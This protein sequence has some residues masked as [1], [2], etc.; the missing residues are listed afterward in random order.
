MH[1]L[2]QLVW[3]LWGLPLLGAAATFAAVPPVSAQVVVDGSITMSQEIVP[4]PDSNVILIPEE[5]GARR[6]DNLIH[7]FEQFN[8]HAGEIADFTGAQV[9]QSVIARVT[10]YARS[11]LAGTIRLTGSLASSDLFLLNPSGFLL[12][13]DVRFEVG[14]TSFLS[15][16]G[17]LE[18]DEGQRLET[19]ATAI[20]DPLSGSP[21]TFEI[22]RSI[23]RSQDFGVIDFRSVSSITATGGFGAIGEILLPE[24]N[25]TSLC[26]P[27]ENS[28]NISFGTGGNLLLINVF[29]D[30]GEGFIGP[31]RVEGAV[32]EA[33]ADTRGVLQLT[34]GNRVPFRG[35]I[36]VDTTQGSGGGAGDVVL[37]GGRGFFD[38]S[39]IETRGDGVTG[40]VTIDAGPGVGVTAVNDEEVDLEGL[41]FTRE[42][43]EEEDGFRREEVEPTVQVAERGP[44]DE[45]AGLGRE[46]RIEPTKPRDDDVAAAREPGAPGDGARPAW[47]PIPD[48]P[49]IADITQP[50]SP[51][52]W[53]D[54]DFTPENFN[55]PEYSPKGRRKP[56]EREPD[57][58][59][60]ADTDV[61]IAIADAENAATAGEGFLATLPAD[62]APPF[63]KTCVTRPDTQRK[64]SLTAQKY[65]LPPSPEGPLA[66]FDILSNLSDFEIPPDRRDENRPR[67]GLE[68]RKEFEQSVASALTLLERGQLEASLEKWV[69][70]VASAAERSPERALARRAAAEVQQALGQ[71]KAS[72][73]TLRHAHEDAGSDA[74][75]KALAIAFL[76]HAQSALGHRGMAVEFLEQAL[77]GSPERS[78]GIKAVFLNN[79][80]NQYS[81]DASLPQDAPKQDALPE[82]VKVQNEPVRA[83]ELYQQSAREA[84]AAGR[85]RI[86]LA[87]LANAARSALQV[88]RS[89]LARELIDEA[90]A[91]AAEIDPDAQAPYV[92]LHL[93]I[94]TRGLA[95]QSGNPEDLRS[96]L[97]AF[98]AAREISQKLED[99][100]A[101]SYAYGLE[102]SLYQAESRIAEALALSR[103]AT[104]AAEQA[105]AP[106]A[107]FRWYRQQGQLFW[108]TGRANEA[109]YALRRA[110]DVLQ[111]AR[112]ESR[113]QLGRP[114]Q[115]R[116]ALAP[117]YYDLINVL[118]AGSRLVESPEDSQALLAEV[119]MV[120]E[121]LKT[122]EVRDYFHDQCISDVARSR[123]SLDEL[124]GD[125]AVVYPVVL[126]D[127]IELIVRLPGGAI[128]RFG[129]AKGVREEDLEKTVDRFVGRILA[130][131]PNYLEDARQLY[132]WLV[133]PF[134]SRLEE[135][136]THT[137]VWV[138]DGAVRRLPVS[139]L[140]DG[141]RFVGERFDLGVIPG[142][143]LLPAQPRESRPRRVLLAGLSQ[144]DLGLPPLPGVRDEI[145]GI[146]EVVGGRRLLDQDFSKQQ[147]QSDIENRDPV[148]VHLASHASF[149]GDADSTF[150]A[151]HESRLGLNELFDIVG[152]K[153]FQIDPLDLVVLSA[154][155][156]ALG[157]DQAALGL[158]GVA[159]RA[160]SRSALGSLWTVDDRSTSELMVEFYKQLA[161]GHS[162]AHAL[163]AAQKKVR[164]SDDHDWSHP[165]YWAP[166]LMINNWR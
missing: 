70:A 32:Q 148:I 125:A 14:G 151:L 25:C 21:A 8:V 144:N 146:G 122:A 46:Q 142:L 116:E 50:D 37:F 42:R 57:P 165:Y 26:L 65:G 92:W 131:D 16:A 163:R 82:H 35:S 114:R 74:A 24:V 123:E 110:V 121:K 105:N 54:G 17:I 145:A 86:E 79:L 117:V 40:G 120:I 55:N 5:L 140:Y 73:L 60:S 47:D 164:E 2:N 134:V 62:Y 11:D 1:P 51:D 83:L 9:T 147:V 99:R 29:P 88:G 6:G 139:A 130:K 94:S 67:D 34:R 71:Y 45:D 66:A 27:G 166:F 43:M 76:G 7:S 133:E 101:E 115:F 61:L 132:E 48:G 109:A 18:F 135:T 39:T 84:R 59:T 58:S 97:G 53:F 77:E 52:A 13:G 38:G 30:F 103:S 81:D 3:R 72:M 152:M 137:L 23:T 111:T 129:S 150:I 93:G 22:D 15:T 4:D 162:K 136:K 98:R 108:A 28:P 159:V 157:D 36:A 90:R 119:R 68:R 138:P 89:S 20:P 10:G 41:P 149:T 49:L 63:P 78:R 31:A 102:A 156:T 126:P 141:E 87:A 91:L 96:A 19:R 118:L 100:R 80:A 124:A 158:S 69:A 75:A 143:S 128:E 33:A 44:V 12:S 153:S 64:G 160:G 95:A 155:Q 85:R 113:D 107:L 161:D 56:G 127:R 154:C 112:I 104:Y 106:D